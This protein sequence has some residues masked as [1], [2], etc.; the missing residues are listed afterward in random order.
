MSHLLTAI[1]WTLLHFCWQ[2]AAIAAL[3]AAATYLLARQSSERRYLLAQCALVGMLLC[4]AF[5]FSWELTA[6]GASFSRSGTFGVYPRTLQ[7]S[8]QLAPAAGAPV[9]LHEETSEPV[10][11]TMLPWI[12]GFWL[13]GVLV[14]SLRSAGGW[15]MI[16]RLKS[17]ASFAVPHTLRSSF[18]AICS[19]LHLRRPTQI[20]VSRTI[21]GP[22]TV[23]FLRPI[24]FLP[25]CALTA[26][27]PE[28]LEVVLA[29]E[30]AHIRRADFLWN[31]LQTFAETVFFFHPAVWWIGS[32]LRAEREL[33]C[34]DLALEVCPNPVVYASA[35]FRLEEQRNQRL[36][37]AMA[38][39]GAGSRATL[40]LRILRILG[41]PVRHAGRSSRAFSITVA[42]VALLLAMA[43]ATQIVSE[44]HPVHAAVASV[45][46]AIA[47]HAKPSAALHPVAAT[48]PQT[49][50]APQQA[51]PAPAT[52]R[53]AE[54]SGKGDYIDRMK[55]AGYD[56]ELDKYVAMKIQGITP[57]YAQQMAQQGFGK[58]SADD[59]VACKIQGVTPEYLNGLKRAGIEPDSLH[60][61]IS[62]RIFQ[63]TPEFISGMKAAGFDHIATKQL[64]ALRVQGVT[65]EYA[66][67]IAQQFPGATVD[68]LVK[69]KIFHIDSA[70]I[71]S[72]KRHGFTG[73][74]FDKL[75][76][77]RISGVLDEKK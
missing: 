71:E 53:A 9:A 36:H 23:G 43:P 4:A 60:E 32:C 16:R 6:Q 14:L 65:P 8:L 75:V 5:T 52:P 45:A 47:P 42:V 63:V 35:L 61:A 57:E 59:L 25:L 13:L 54:P 2:A 72:A 69:A 3:Y 38:L 62:F 1:A 77:L 74:T 68:D 31:L 15:W 39:D 21:A 73:L 49:H 66:R 55:A 76:R 40:R 51:A 46:H 10:L 30:L 41:E 7:Q 64:V 20:A 70:F 28:E 34:D 24:V 18:D 48:E 19:R 58:L 50:A 67:A 11:A 37:L 44:V 27:G 56:V 26:L 22:F 12:D 33:C 29:H 17:S